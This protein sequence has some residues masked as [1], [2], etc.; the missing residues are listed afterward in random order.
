MD[1]VGRGLQV[2]RQKSKLHKG[3]WMK[4]DWLCQLSDFALEGILIF[5][6][7]SV[8][9]ISSKKMGLELGYLHQLT[10]LRV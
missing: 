6:L 10:D 1:K 7:Y 2:S 5:E 3:M 4:T 8:Y 9:G